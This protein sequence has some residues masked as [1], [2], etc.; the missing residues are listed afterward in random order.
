MKVNNEREVSEKTEKPLSIGKRLSRFGHRFCVEHDFLSLK[1]VRGKTD[2][3]RR[4]YDFL[5]PVYDLIYPRS[6]SYLASAHH[7]TQN[8]VRPG[9][10]ALDLGAGTGLLTMEMLQKALSVVSYDLHE[11]MLIKGRQ[12]VQKVIKKSDF[13]PAGT[14]FCQGDALSLPFANDSFNLVVSAFMLVYLSKEQKLAALKEVRRVLS[15]GGRVALLTFQGEI[16]PR[17]TPRAGWRELF[18]RAGF[19][20]PNFDDFSEVFRTIYLDT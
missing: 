1:K 3:I 6:N 5:A 17:F 20:A 7:V 12:K 13:P 16:H 11:K 19:E 15:D 14:G 4:F 2:T 10:K 9:D 8:F 18:E